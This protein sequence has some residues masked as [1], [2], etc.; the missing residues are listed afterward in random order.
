MNQYEP[1]FK[2][3]IVSMHKTTSAK[4]LVFITALLILSYIISCTTT[5]QI[6]DQ[7]Q[8]KTR[9]AKIYNVQNNNGSKDLILTHTKTRHF[10]KYGDLVEL[11]SVDSEGKDALRDHETL[12]L[13][14]NMT[15]DYKYKFYPSGEI[16]KSIAIRTEYEREIVEYNK[17]GN[18]VLKQWFYKLGENSD[19]EPIISNYTTIYEY[20]SD[21]YLEKTFY[22]YDSSIFENKSDFK[23]KA[24]Y[25]YE[26]IDNK[27][28][29]EYI[30]DYQYDEEIRIHYDDN[31]KPLKKV[32]LNN[33]VV[34]RS[35]HYIYKNGILK[36]M[37]S[38][39][40]DNED[41]LKW[42]EVAVYDYIYW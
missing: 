10:N 5:T 33:S 30:K 36:K 32:Y 11:I 39:F 27:I 42:E 19:G 24:D 3:N 41:G 2:F 38:Y 4:P 15:W 17:K 22:S 18:I 31:E 35:D 29:T 13:V 28:K 7:R 14:K 37:H 25:S 20:N 9:I 1:S 23:L 16:K 6:V 21:G 26:F 8:I 12:K 40:Y 34:L